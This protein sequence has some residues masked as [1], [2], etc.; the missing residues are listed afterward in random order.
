MSTNFEFTHPASLV[1]GDLEL[2]LKNTIPGDDTKGYVPSYEFQL[3]NR[4]TGEFMGHIHLRIGNNENIFY[5]GHIGYGVDEKFRGQHYAARSCRLLFPLAKRHGLTTI[6][7]T[8]DPDNVAS[9]RTCEL[10]GGKF[11]DIV[12]LPRDNDQY[13]HGDRQ[14]CRYRFDL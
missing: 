8:C 5:G 9:R 1:D 6:W 3:Q 4:N 11:V 14:K 10:A 2:V 12:D 13:L 7:I